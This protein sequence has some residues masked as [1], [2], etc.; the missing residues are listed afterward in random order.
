MNR[1]KNNLLQ[2]DRKS[3]KAYKQIA[4]SYTYPRY[5]LHI[6]YV[7]GDPFA[8][9]SKI[10]IVIPEKE[11]HIASDWL[12][13]KS[14][15]VAVED[16]FA[17]AVDK[18]VKQNK[19]SINGS[20]KSGM[21]AFDGPGQEILE[22][23]AVNIVKQEI[24][25]CLS[26][27]LPANGRSINGKEAIKLFNQAIPDLLENST[28][29][30]LD[31]DIQQAVQ[32]ADQQEAIWQAMKE[33]NWVS[34]IA[35]GSILPRKSGVSDLPAGG[36]IAFQSPPEDE[37]ELT[38]PHG[39]IVKGMAVKQGVTLITGGGY[40]GKS[41]LLQAIERGIYPHC[42]GDGREF[43][44]TDPSAVKI[45]AEDGREISSVNISPF[46]SNLPH[47]KDT[48]SFST[49]NASGSTS[50]AANVMEALEVGAETLLIDEDTSATN[51]MIRDS[52]MQK[53]IDPE[54]EPIT[55]FIHRIRQLVDETDKSVV[56]VTG[57]S[58]DYFAVAD[59]VILMKEYKPKNV[60]QRAKEIIKEDPIANSNVEPADFTSL[61]NRQLLASTFP[62]QT[63]KRFKIQAKG[64]FQILFG[65]EPISFA[66]TEQ[67]VDAS[68][69]RMIAEII[70]YL[71]RNEGSNFSSFAALIQYVDEKM[72]QGLEKLTK[73]NEKHPGD[74][75]RPRKNEIAAVLNR[76]RKAKFSM[77]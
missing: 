26:V 23:T 6:D 59:T 60:T 72:D 64:Q 10:R 43:I 77:K 67:L 35:N 24:T 47:G 61:Q 41:T 7:Q 1:L 44:C 50:Q 12:E 34:F 75:A 37:V 28:F 58:G 9:P 55:P 74:L 40:H 14:R 53:L 4:G 29:K 76:M 38:L 30:I 49:T 5:A 45:R 13:T 8:S 25:V 69:T 65:K 20:G 15:R 18:A 32:L 19:V 42:Q 11:R 21:I 66:Y 71:Y 54:N 2:I 68:Q 16:A 36:A 57:G 48:T 27:G 3:Y 70:Q 73:S 17:R 52:R 39:K 63:D 46:I 22:R 33:N 56:L 31:K 62:K 51:F